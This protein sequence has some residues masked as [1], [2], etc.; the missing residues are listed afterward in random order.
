M[1]V[2]IETPRL[3]LRP[4]VLD[5]YNG[6]CAMFGD[7]DFYRLSGLTPQSPEEVW[8]RLLRYMG[9][10]TAFGW[11]LFAA[12]EK[13]TGRFV[14]DTGLADFHRGLGPDFDLSPEAAWAIT[15]ACQGRGYA[16]EAVRA[17]HH[18]FDAT[19]P[20]R[21]VCIIDPSNTPSQKVAAALGYT[22]FADAPY[23]G[24]KVTMYERYAGT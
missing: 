13:D 14:G 2:M 8:H 6:L 10:W 9:H 17:A 24:H 7:P 15:P 21:T 5:D 23:K 19:H 16:L 18:W 11:G 4:H 12:I 20:Q 22:A 3:I 1:G